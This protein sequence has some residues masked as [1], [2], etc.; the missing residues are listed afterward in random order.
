MNSDKGYYNST[1]KSVVGV[2]AGK[3]KMKI[4]VKNT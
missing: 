2:A 1:S 3:I 4:H